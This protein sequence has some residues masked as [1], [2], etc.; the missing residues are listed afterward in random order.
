MTRHIILSDTFSSSTES[1]NYF[2]KLNIP[3]S[4]FGC[5]CQ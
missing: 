3:S 1:A 5:A 2:K 4:A